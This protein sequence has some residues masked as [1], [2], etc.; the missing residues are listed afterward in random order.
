M[1]FPTLKQTLHALDDAKLSQ[2]QASLDCL[3][4]VLRASYDDDQLSKYD[5]L[6]DQY[7]DVTDGSDL[8]QDV[9]L[10]M[11]HFRSC[12]VTELIPALIGY[13]KDD[14]Q[15]YELG[16]ALI[17]LVFPRKRSAVLPETLIESQREVLAALTE[18]DA[19]WISDATFP[20]LLKGRGLPTGKSKAQQLV[21][22]RKKQG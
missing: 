15:F 4:A 8:Q 10:A 3:F 11:P 17:S 12:D 14:D 1:A 19:I 5:K 2:S 13:Y 7:S 20:T 9:V 22:K 6:S 16:H 18:T 21:T